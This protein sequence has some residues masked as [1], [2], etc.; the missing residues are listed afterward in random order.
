MRKQNG[1]TVRTL[2]VDFDGVSPKY[3]FRVFVISDFY[4]IIIYLP[5]LKE[6]LMIG[7]IYKFVIFEVFL[8][9]LA[10]ILLRISYFEISLDLKGHT[11]S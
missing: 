8:L 7:R 2:S 4:S 6:R 10:S 9:L 11:G 1:L 3:N 5:V